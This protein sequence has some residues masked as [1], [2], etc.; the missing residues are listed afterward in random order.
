MLVIPAEEFSDMKQI[1]LKVLMACFKCTECWIIGLGADANWLTTAPYFWN[2]LT[3]LIRFYEQSH[4]KFRV[5]FRLAFN[6]E[7]VASILA[8]IAVDERRLGNIQSHH[9]RYSDDREAKL[10]LYFPCFNAM[11]S[12]IVLQDFSLVDLLTLSLE[13]LNETIQIELLEKIKVRPLSLTIY[14]FI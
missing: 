1:R 9:R 14:H 3:G 6:I 7:Q 4:P 13:T 8:D 10:L 11:S 5:R 12:H 2:P